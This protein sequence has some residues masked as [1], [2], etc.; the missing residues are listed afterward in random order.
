MPPK[1]VV[2]WLNMAI[3]ADAIYIFY[4]CCW[5]MNQ[6]QVQMS[7]VFR[8][9]FIALFCIAS[10]SLKGSAQ[11]YR[12]S[13]GIG[14][15]PEMSLSFKHFVAKQGALEAQ[16]G[17]NL[18]AK[19][20]MASI[21]YQHHVFMHHGFAFYCGGGLNAGILYATH[22]S[23]A[24]FAAGVTPVVGFEYTFL[25]APVALAIDYRPNIN[26]VGPMQWALAAFKV[27]FTW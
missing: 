19:G 10:T 24:T 25:G 9:C 2:I 5:V 14:L 18:P 22:R 3:F 21:V 4:F 23:T 15:G 11:D 16:L 12:S 6:K 20:G 8:V 17:V 13:V 27:R 7:R 1:A 26:F